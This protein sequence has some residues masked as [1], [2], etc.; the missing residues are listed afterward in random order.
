MQSV[1]LIGM[2][3]GH[4]IHALCKAFGL[5]QS[6]S[7]WEYGQVIDRRPGG[8]CTVHQSS[9]PNLDLDHQGLAPSGLV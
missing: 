3:L 6:E 7:R 5:L 1:Y 9:S 4:R 8:I 2:L